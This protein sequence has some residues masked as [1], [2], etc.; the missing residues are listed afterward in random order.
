[1]TPDAIAAH[2]VGKRYGGVPALRAVSLSLRAGEVMALL[3]ANGAGKSTLIGVLSGAVAPDEGR[4]EVAGCILPGGDVTAARRAGV[5]VVHQ[6]LML[7]PDRSVVENVTA[8][9]LP[10][11]RGGL[12]DKRR[13]RTAAAATLAR[14]GLV[15]PLDARVAGLSLAERQLVEIGRALLT[16]GRVLILDEPTSAL[17]LRETDALLSIIRAL[18][19]EGTAVLFV[20]HRLDEATRIADRLTVLRDGQVAGVWQRGTIDVSGIARAMVGDVPVHSAPAM[21]ASG[22][23]VLQARELRGPGLGPLTLTVHAGEIVGFVGLE[24]S[25]IDT[26]LRGLGGAAPLEGAIA[27]SGR[28]LRL[29]YPADALRAGLVY[30][31]PDRKL[32]G[33]WLDR[34]PV[35]NI[36]TAPLRR[37]A[38]WRW[39]GSGWLGRLARDR[40][41]QLSVRLTVAD[42]PVRHLSGGN[43]QRVLFARSLEQAPAVLLLSD[44]TRGVDVRAKS[45]IHKLIETLAADGIAVCLACSGIDEVLA[46]AQR[47]VCM[48]AG[49]IVAD[50]PRGTF[51][52]ARVLAIVSSGA[53][54][55]S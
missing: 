10:L 35:W 8:T 38:A 1:M 5:S 4:V 31:P 21:R 48:R 22:R 11:H 2:G 46:L 52:E 51:D 25:G 39:P 43:Q 12:L 33:L 36:A 23:P 30:M 41:A 37:C 53:A 17:S 54:G 16:G 13:Q 9:A 50:G 44:P 42:A 45:D 26:L 40:M 14:L 28:P 6:D 19:A 27:V 20:S 29:S 18:A 49:R 3:G 55:P 47:I 24:G 32:E 34:S 7:F 15:V